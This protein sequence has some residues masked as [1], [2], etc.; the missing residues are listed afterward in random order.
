MV[1]GQGLK[2]ARYRPFAIEVGSVF[3]ALPAIVLCFSN[4]NGDSVQSS[5]S[6]L[7]FK[8]Q[9]TRSEFYAIEG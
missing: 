1:G 4:L 8:E 3:E 7:K 6:I 5:L 2:S 9:L